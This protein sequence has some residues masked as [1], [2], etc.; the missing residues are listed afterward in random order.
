[1]P[2]S[3]ARESLR[4]VETGNAPSAAPAIGTAAGLRLRERLPERQLQTVFALAILGIAAFILCRALAVLI[5]ALSV[6]IV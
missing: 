5:L 4:L 2:V 1:M 6:H 3:L